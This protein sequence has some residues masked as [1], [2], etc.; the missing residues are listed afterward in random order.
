MKKIG[1]VG[2]QKEDIFG[3]STQYMEWISQFGDVTI[4]SPNA[5]IDKSLDLLI[6]QGGSDINPMTYG[7]APFFNLKLS[8]PYLDYFD[9]EILPKYIENKTPIFGI[10]RGMQALNVAFGGTLKNINGHP[11]NYYGDRKDRKHLI[12]D[13]D[14]THSVNS[15]H[16]QIIENLGTNIEAI[17]YH[18]SDKGIQ[19]Q[20]IEAIQHKTLPIFGVQYHPEEIYDKFAIELVNKLL[21]PNR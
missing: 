4:L 11:T 12:K 8:N 19:K 1:I 20:T 21:T 16:H 2:T 6:L 9:K 18:C 14:K 7:K 3:V 5:K 17:A 15:L 13:K 10:C